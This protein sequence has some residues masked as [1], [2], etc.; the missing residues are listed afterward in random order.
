MT[1]LLLVLVVA[2]KVEEQCCLMFPEKMVVTEENCRVTLSQDGGERT[3]EFELTLGEYT[4]KELGVEL[5]LRINEHGH[6]YEAGYSEAINK[7]TI[8]RKDVDLDL[9]APPPEPPPT[10]TPPTTITR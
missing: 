4:P 6:K 9:L 7:F 5:N 2:E 10:I 3:S 8:M 1:N